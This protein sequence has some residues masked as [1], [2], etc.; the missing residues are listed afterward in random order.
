MLGQGRRL[1]G[2]WESATRLK[3]LSVVMLPN[4]EGEHCSC[5]VCVEH[6]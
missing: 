4:L 6:T 1:S 5:Y 3:K 2:G